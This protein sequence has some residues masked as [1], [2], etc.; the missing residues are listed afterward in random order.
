MP[1]Q[2]G[3]RTYR[4][5]SP[6]DRLGN[7]R[8]VEGRESWP[9]VHPLRLLSPNEGSVMAE[10]LVVICD[11]CGR[12]AQASVTFRVAGRS[13]SKDLCQVHLQELVR[14]AHPPKRG[15]RPSIASPRPVAPKS[16]AGRRGR[17]SAKAS[18]KG[19]ARKASRATV[20]DPETLKKR[21]AALEKARRV[22]AAK[23]AAAKKT[24]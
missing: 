12:P 4:Q 2:K 8:G 23:R 14:N 15:R 6:R 9:C 21:R 16:S 17:A 13:L 18:P 19:Q 7:G 10:R 20:T 24:S 1:F 5:G 11:E 3:S 22:L